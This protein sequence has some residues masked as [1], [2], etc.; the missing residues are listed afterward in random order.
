MSKNWIIMDATNVAW[1]QHH[2]MHHLTY[3]G[4]STG[5]LFGFFRSIVT[6]QNRF[7]TPHVVFCFDEGTSLRAKECLTYKQNRRKPSEIAIDEIQ[8]LSIAKGQIVKLRSTY[9][10]EIGFRNVFACEGYEA[11][12]IIASVC[13]S[14]PTDDTAI[15]V[16]TD[17]DLYQLLTD[18]ISIWNPRMQA[19]ISKEEFIK[20]YKIEPSKWVDVKAL[21]GCDSDCI[22]GV[23]GIGEKRAILYLT[24]KLKYDSAAYKAASAGKDIWERNIPLVRLPYQDCPKY[25]LRKDEVTY[26]AWYRVLDSLGIKKIENLT[27]IIQGD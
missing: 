9:L 22:K 26:E 2:A 11:D 15:L 24:N 1:I 12:D 10:P 13:C 5:L 18:K 8:T 14:L 17:Q 21:A 23:Q 6:L 19:V 3:R 4:D 20:A 25:E 16:S 27:P 7:A